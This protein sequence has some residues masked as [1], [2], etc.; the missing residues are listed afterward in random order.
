MFQLLTLQ[1]S[2]FRTFA[3]DELREKSITTIGQVH[4]S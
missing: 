1:I 4:E 3:T 2:V